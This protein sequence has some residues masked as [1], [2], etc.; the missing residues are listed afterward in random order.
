M[1]ELEGVVLRIQRTSIHDGEGLRT[2]VF[3]KG[4]PLNC[5]WCSTPESQNREKQRGYSQESCSSCGECVGTCPVNA[6]AMM[7]G[8]IKHNEELCTG[9]FSCVDN[10]PSDA[11]TGYG[12]IMSVSQVVQEI[13]K[14]EVF[15]F[16]SGGG[17]TISGGECLQQSD[18]TA[19]I[20]QKCKL[21]GIDT[22]VETSLYAPWKN[23]MKIIS[24][25]SDIYVDLKHPD[26]TEHSKI[27]GVDNTLILK[28]LRKL[29]QTDLALKVHLRIPLIPGV[30]DSDEAL[31][32][33]AAI[34]RELKKVHSI[35]I[36]PYHR[37]GVATYERLQRRYGLKTLQTP[38]KEYVEN[39]YHHLCN[40]VERNIVMAST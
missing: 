31:R 6:L 8:K 40:Y 21:Y 4:C 24:Y 10:C 5:I 11:V 1:N 22:A 35:E 14:D 16:H 2:V 33:T 15:F 20:L 13:A 29:D 32:R 3:L 23:V 26:G 27:T 25:L 38:T 37:L 28:N 19:A 36:L 9:C 12:Q 18:F 30:N 17:V 39:R 7:D 34:A